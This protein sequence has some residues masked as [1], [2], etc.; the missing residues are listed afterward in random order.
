[1]VLWNCGHP[2]NK[3]INIETVNKQTGKYLHRFG[4]L[5]NDLI[6]SIDYKWNWLVGWY[7]KNKIIRPNAIHFT[8]GGPWFKNYEQCDFANVWRK[9]KSQMIKFNEKKNT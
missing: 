9:Y 2:E 7:K 8:E 4:W 5:S 3:K 1:M 6:G